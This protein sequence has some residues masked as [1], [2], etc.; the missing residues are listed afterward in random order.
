MSN[1]DKKQR[2][3]GSRVGRRAFLATTGAAVGGLAAGCLGGGGSSSTP[4]ARV[5]TRIVTKEG[6]GTVV[7]TVKVTQTPMKTFTNEAG[8]Q[9]GAN[10]DAVQTLAKQEGVTTWYA[11]L[12]REAMAPVVKAFQDKFGISVNHVTGGSETILNRFESEYKAGHSIADSMVVG[13]PK[14]SQVWHNGQAMEL[15][16]DVMPSY[17]EMPDKFKDSENNYWIS[18]R[19]LMSS[20]FYNTDHVSP[21][22]A[23]DWLG[24]VTN[25]KFANGNIGHDPSPNIGMVSWLR[26]KYGDKYFQ[27]L[28]KDQPNW[29]DSHTDLARFCG[30]GQFD[31]AF[32][33]THK[34]GRFGDSLPIDYFKFDPM[35][36]GLSPNIVNN[37][38]PAPNAGIL[39]FNWLE[40]LEGQNTLGTTEYI[41]VHP[42]AKYTG[43]PNVYPSTDYDVDT[44]FT[45]YQTYQDNLKYWGDIMK[46]YL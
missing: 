32:T 41:P 39:W 24:V 1:D 43:Y 42:K 33:Y 46:P 19:Q 44:F 2:K 28:G 18:L 34:M 40:S 22:D 5:E 13:E 35:P 30:A 37:K 14:I 25:S 20:Y 12:D 21:S 27:A 6:G 17:G 26:G 10:F 45:D 31:V 15:N 9:V 8:K 11:T 36:S 23:K 29:T 4:T 3:T 38:A 16:A 7:K